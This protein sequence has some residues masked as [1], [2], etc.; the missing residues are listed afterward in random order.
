MTE[1]ILQ[2]VS[3]TTCIPSLG[4]DLRPQDPEVTLPTA[5]TCLLTLTLPTAIADINI[6]K[7]RITYAIFNTVGFGHV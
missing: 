6:L 4:F 5:S 1:N 7:K 3:G 2:F